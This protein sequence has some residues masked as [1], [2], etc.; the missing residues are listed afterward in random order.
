MRPFSVLMLACAAPL[1]SRCATAVKPVYAEQ[2]AALAAP[3][4]PTQVDDVS[5]AFE[6]PQPEVNSALPPQKGEVFEAALR[7]ARLQLKRKRLGDALG[8]SASLREQ[9]SHLGGAAFAQAAAFHF[10]VLKAE[11]QWAEAG[12]WAWEW[13]R[14]CG[15]EKIEPCRLDAARALA[16]VSGAASVPKTLKQIAA[17][18]L[19]TEQCLR[20]ATPTPDCSATAQRFADQEHDSV[21]TARLLLQRAAHEDGEAAEESVLRRAEASCHA[22]A[23]GELR[24]RALRRLTQLALGR[25]NVEL[26][27]GYAFK[28]TE[29]FLESAP[30][31]Q[32]TWA[33]P[34]TLDSVCEAYESKNGAGSCRSIEKKR[35]GTYVFH[36]FSKRQVGDGL[37][38]EDVRRVGAHYAPLLQNCLMN[39]AR[40]LKSG[41][42]EK[43][44]IR[45][46]VQNDGRVGDAHLTRKDLDTT[47]LAQCMRNQFALWRYPKFRGEWQNVEQI[48][49]VSTAA[50]RDPR[51]RPP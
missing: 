15:P 24:R 46:T 31:D 45:W 13:Y 8:T 49:S 16:S 4:W 42:Q 38:P 51:S 39:H 22:A 6:A 12:T 29:V 3:E 25:A 23:C 48:F 43:Y 35:L 36:D 7:D 11:K 32:R 10:D 40:T 21:T 50:T 33:R 20:S 18:L 37:P 44:G 34:E 14:Q 28:E 19:K 2:K 17:L 26:A 47:E 5:S 1:I 30:E 27:L 41:E 9:A